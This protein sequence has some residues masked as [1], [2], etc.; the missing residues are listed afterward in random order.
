MTPCRLGLSVSGAPVLTKA[1]FR[2][3]VAECAPE[4][5]HRPIARRLGYMYS[6]RAPVPGDF[7]V[8]CARMHMLVAH[9]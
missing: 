3:L 6:G 8:M 9:P 7:A 4:V 5:L 1:F 2:H